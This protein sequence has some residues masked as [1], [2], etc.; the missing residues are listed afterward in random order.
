MQ[1]NPAEDEDSKGPSARI[2]ILDDEEDVAELNA[3]ILTRTGYKVDVFNDAEEAL[4]QLKTQRYA[5]I[6]SD[7]N[8]PVLGGR[9]FFEIIVRDFPDMINRT[10]FVTGDTMGRSSQ[11]FL[12]EAKRPFIEKPVSPKELR[13]FVAEILAQS[14][15]AG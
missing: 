11:T 13:A 1:V 10:G 8:M 6:I 9:G 7:L 2:L 12:G 5:L 4:E 14:D 15:Q 3:E